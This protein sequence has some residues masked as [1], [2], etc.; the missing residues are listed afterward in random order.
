MIHSPAASK[1][2]PYE[3]LSYW[4]IVL[5]LASTVAVE[6]VVPF[7]AWRWRQQPFPGFLVEHTLV[8]SGIRN[9]AWG[10]EVPPNP[11]GRLVAINGQPLSDGPTLNR[12]L[13]NRAVGEQV[14][15]TFQYHDGSAPSSL[16]A[17]LQRF[18][19]GDWITLFWLPYLVGLIYLTIGIWVFLHRGQERPGQSFGLFCAFVALS[20][21]TLFDL[22]TTYAFVRLWTAALPLAGAALIHLAMVFPEEG[23]LTRRRP[24]IRF[25]PYPLAILL[26]ALAEW[27]LYTP[28]DAWAYIPL[29][30]W[31]YSFLTIALLAFL[32]LMFYT[33]A[34]TLSGIVRRQVRLILVGSLMA[35]LPI[36][37][38]LLLAGLAVRLQFRTALYLPPLVAFPAFIAYAILRYRLLR[39]DVVVSRGLAYALL[40]ASVAGAYFLA[41]AVLSQALGMDITGGHPLLLTLLVI[42]LILSYNPLRQVTERLADRLL[43]R[44]RVSYRQALQEF[45]HRLVTTPLEVRAILQQLIAQIEPISHSAPVLVFLYDPLQDRYGLHQASRFVPPE[46]REVSFDQ[47]ASL[48]QWLM[49]QDGAA[50]LMEGTGRPLSAGLS[51]QDWERLRSLGLALLLPLR[52]KGQA[53]E[54]RLEGWVALGPRLSGEPY[55]PDDLAFLA[56]LVDQTAMAVD[57]ARLLAEARHR[58]E[59]LIALQQTAVEISTRQEIPLLLQSITER[60]VRLLNATGGSIYLAEEEAQQLRLVASY[61]L[62]NSYAN[63]TLHWGE[64]VAGRVALAGQPLRVENYQE[65]DGRAAAFAGLPIRSVLGVP[66]K[67]DERVIGVLDVFDTGQARLFSQ[68]DEWLLTLFAS[69]AAIALRNAQLLADLERR[70]I[71]LDALRQIGQAVDLRRD[72]EDLLA[73]IYEQTRRVMEADNFYVALYDETAQ[74]L[75]FAYYVQEGERRQPEPSTWPLGTGLTSQIVL[76]R[77]PIVTDDYLTE[78]QRQGVPHTGAPGR[79]WLGVPL[80]TG[81]RVLGVLNVSSFKPDYRYAPEQVQLLAAIADQA[82]VAIDRM[83]LYQEMEARA[84]ELVTLNEVSRTINSTLDLPVVLDLIMNKVIELLNVEAGSLLLVDEE[85]GDLVFQVT[86]GTPLSHSLTGR[87]HPMGKG[88]AGYV[89][90]TGQSQIVNNVT[91]DPRWNQEVDQEIGFMTRSILCVPMISR[92]RVIGVIEVINHRDGS[93]FRESEASLLTNFAAQAAV[94]IENARLYTR[95]DQA[96]ARRVEELSTMQRI[97]RQLNATLEF[98]RVMDMTLDWALRGTRAPVGVIALYDETRQGLLLLAS[99]GYTPEFERYRTEPWPLSAGIAGRVIRTGEPALVAD[100]SQDPDYRAAQPATRSQLTVPIRRE[101]QVIGIINVESPELAAFDQDDLTFIQ[102]LADHAA[103]AIENARLYRQSQQRAEEMALLYDISLAVSAHLTLEEVLEAVYRRLRDVWDPP[104][105]FIALYD[106]VDDA[107]EFPLYM[108]R[109]QRLEPFRQRLAEQSGF[110]AWIVRQRQPILIHDWQEEASSS[111]VQGIPI[112]DL[113]RSWLGVPLLAGDRLVGVMALQDY[114]PNSYGEEHKRLLSTIAGEV[115]IALE[116]ARLYEGVKQANQAKSEFIDF[117]AHELKQ[118]MTAMQGYARLLTMGVGGELNDTQ[119]Q[120]VQVINAN[121][122]RMGKLVNDLLE[123]SRLEAGRIKLKLA[124]VQLRE[125]IEETVTNTR[126]EIEARHHRLEVE[127]PDDLPPVLGD[128]ER[129]V[130]ILTNLVSNAYKYTPDGGTIRIAVDGREQGQIPP[131]HLLVS[132]SDT[133]IGMS[134]QELARLEEKFFRADHSLV[135]SQPGTGLGISITRNLVALHG[136]EFMV[137]S[138]PGVGSTFR[139]T[140][141]IARAAQLTQTLSPPSTSCSDCGESRGQSPAPRSGDRPPVGQAA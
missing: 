57:N 19:R 137:E 94:A 88:I 36:A 138:K 22:N 59:E 53:P 13:R 12:L 44:E 112:G 140:V 123:I 133:G 102:R 125:V 79:A 56:A 47:D 95:T 33:R 83:Q 35:F 75:R 1:P 23:P 122:E 127:V 49:E 107:L 69:Q 126:T 17:T 90:Q 51:D 76:E 31:N 25:F 96:L 34:R 29:W 108:D 20:T 46:G 7:I 89:A 84:A 16:S 26:A 37:I 72:L 82:A 121:I 116:N 6:L 9:P 4:G 18:P 111:P 41:L 73:L 124:A 85:R 60:A 50:Y 2:T 77:R 67:W 43:G 118:P 97:D 64:G 104:V 99:R 15:F 131:D 58:A 139:F 14:L 117:V 86:L 54:K 5:I 114:A 87:R 11:D 45:S 134:P 130:Q 65:F 28:A 78:C 48:V 81:S 119:K 105:F 27:R 66:L 24:V 39:M 136:G 115:A 42:F 109:G 32:G 135:R 71:Q 93:P 101:E 70:V 120:F 129:L 40:I 30:R 21:G 10:V 61:G 128:R 62:G 110:W 74:E 141:P 63:T 55:S 91:A 52:G 113:T 8:V 38:Y 80:I 68:E 100:V 106:E 132:V 92:D 98:E 103:I 3:R